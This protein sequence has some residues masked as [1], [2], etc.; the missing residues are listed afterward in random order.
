[1]S[2]ETLVYELANQKCVVLMSPPHA[3]CTG[4]AGLSTGGTKFFYFSFF[5]EEYNH[6]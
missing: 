6:A 2:L 3:T 1:M 5:K 4:H